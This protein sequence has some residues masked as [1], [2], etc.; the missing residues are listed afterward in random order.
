M[1]KKIEQIEIFEDVDQLLDFCIDS[2][3]KQAKGQARNQQKP[4]EDKEQMV[5]IDDEKIKIWWL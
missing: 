5:V 2:T 4:A 1:S 3:P